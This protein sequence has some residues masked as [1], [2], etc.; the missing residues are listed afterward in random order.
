MIV[1]GKSDA[2]VEGGS[3][4]V[5]ISTPEAPWVGR[6]TAKTG[7]VIAKQRISGKIRTI[8]RVTERF[9]NSGIGFKRVRFSCIGAEVQVIELAICAFIY[10]CRRLVN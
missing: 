7:S 4:G 2:D 9:L 5:V 8:A 1:N 6:R 3:A 10:E